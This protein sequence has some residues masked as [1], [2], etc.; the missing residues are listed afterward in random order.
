MKIK[1]AR[2]ALEAEW[3]KLEKRKAWDITR[4]QPKAKVIAD[5]K[6]ANRPVHFG[7]LM[8]LC[9]IKNSQMGKEFWSYKGRIVFRGD[10]VKDE[11]GS[12]AVFTEQGASASNMAAAKF[13][14]AIART[15]GC[16]G[17][18]SDAKGAYTQVSLARAKELLGP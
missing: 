13:M 5:A 11:E 9:H 7:S 14:D 3:S 16:D 12:F 6:A 17:E 4:V 8:D 18:D 2:E 15:P 1:K 10:I